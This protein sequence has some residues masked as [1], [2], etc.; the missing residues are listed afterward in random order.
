MKLYPLEVSDP[1]GVNPQESS[2]VVT[3]EGT[4]DRTSVKLDPPI[5]QR[6]RRKAT[7][8]AL[9]NIINVKPGPGGCRK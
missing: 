3:T 4:I 6:V 8:E 1:D 2:D 5:G 7:S 9:E